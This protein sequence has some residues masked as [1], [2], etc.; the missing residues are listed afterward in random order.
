MKFCLLISIKNDN[1]THLWFKRNISYRV[2]LIIMYNVFC[3]NLKKKSAVEGSRDVPPK[4]TSTKLQKDAKDINVR[5]SFNNTESAI[6]VVWVFFFQILHQSF[7]MEI[8]LLSI[9]PMEIA[10]D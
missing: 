2:L 9:I 8:C 7:V 4:A 6:E 10:D 3:N 1:L 5:I